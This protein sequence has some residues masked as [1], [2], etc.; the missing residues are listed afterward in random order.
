MASPS[1][2]TWEWLNAAEDRYATVVRHLGAAALDGPS[3]LPGWGRRHVLAHV[4]AN[5]DAIGNLVAWA[6]TGLPTPMYA[7]PAARVSAIEDGSRLPTDELLAWS[8]RS[9]R[10]LVA[11]LRALPDA[12]W[13]EVVRT[14]QGREVAA[15]HL[16]WM[17]V[18]ET[19]V[20]VVDL[21]AGVGFVD[22]EPDLA[23]ALVDDIVARRRDMAGHP[24][25][26]L[27]DGTTSWS[28][29][30]GAA[31]EQVCGS[32]DQLLFYLTGRSGGTPLGGPELPRWL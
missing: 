26:R 2:R 18:R 14:A 19:A 1:A 10:G 25:V 3:L 28:I 7:S 23:H 21:A 22:L 15:S 4:A 12:D 16:P 13:D 30:D 11:A 31:A 24:A 5:A 29:G 32:V 9:G 8:S 6:R 27:S 17:R 20:H